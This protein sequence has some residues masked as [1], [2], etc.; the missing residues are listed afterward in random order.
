MHSPHIPTELPVCLST[1]ILSFKAQVTCL[2]VALLT[3]LHTHISLM[4]LRPTGL[5][6]RVKGELSVMA[7]G[8]SELH[9]SRLGSP[10]AGILII[11]SYL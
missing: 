2:L 4:T 6:P 3:H 5:L 7:R 11:W 1:E 10:R 9:R 8:R